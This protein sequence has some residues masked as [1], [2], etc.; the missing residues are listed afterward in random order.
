[1]L[2]RVSSRIPADLWAPGRAEKRAAALAAADLARHSGGMR[3]HTE[4]LLASP[5]HRLMPLCCS[6]RKKRR[7]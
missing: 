2:S 6:P 5:A 3:N 4:A 1:M 7:P